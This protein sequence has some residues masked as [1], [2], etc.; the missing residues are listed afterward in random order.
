MTGASGL[1]SVAVVLDFGAATPMSVLAAARGLARIVFLCDRAGSYTHDDAAELAGLAEVWDITG[2]RVEDIAADRRFA[3]LAGITTFSERQLVRTAALAH[4]RGLPFLSPRAAD[5]ATD[6]F[7]QR[8]ML[9]DAGVDHT[10]C[11]TVRGADQ[12]DAALADVGL[13]AVL[14]P[15]RGAAGARTC[16][17]DSVAEAHRRLR[18]FLATA[19]TRGEYVV[20]RLLTGDPTVAGNGWGDYVSVESVTS[21]GI[22]RHLDITGKFPLAPPMRETGYVVPATL[23]PPTRRAVLELAG[24]AIRAL[25][26]DHGA[27]HT[28]VK[29]TPSGPR[30]IEVNGRLGGYVADLVRR[31]SGYDL[32]RATLLCALGRP[33]E[34]PPEGY[35]RHAFQYF[36]TPPVEAVALRRL[37]GADALTRGRGIHLVETV[38]QPGDPLDWRDGTLTYV[39]IVHGSG[40]D[41]ADVLRLVD[42]IEH[43]LRVEYDIATEA[44][45]SL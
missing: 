2:L 39:G 42:H 12:L 16:R 9:A 15:R 7:R 4:H 34:P 32:L 40:T 38:K 3:G 29:L 31:A 26:I 24:A 23:D 5:A 6:K 41:H 30:V 37:D 18:D 10:T 35:R 14:K 1:P 33:A 36:L 11:R 20:E 45:K 25:G 17:V 43:T 13:P 28:E 27:T 21:H 8:Q 19:P 44:D 22:T